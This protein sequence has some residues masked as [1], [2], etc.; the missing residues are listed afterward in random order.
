[1]WAGTT[2]LMIER[3]K[4]AVMIMKKVALIIAAAMVASLLA[5]CG[6]GSGVSGGSN[7]LALLLEATEA[8][9]GTGGYRMR[10]DIEIGMGAGSAP[11]AMEIRADVQNATDGMRQH[12]FVTMGGFEAEAYIVGDTYYQ[13]TPGEGW[14]KMSLGLYKAQ[15]M[16]MGLAD[17]DQVELMAK[18]AA[19]SR[20][21][22][23]KDGRVGIAFHL[24][25]EYFDASMQAYRKY[26][27]EG[28]Q[29][30]SPEWLDMIEGSVKDFGADIRMWIGTTSGLIER[31]E[32]EYSMSGVPQVGEIT[33]ST[34]LDLYDHDQALEI[35]L[36]PE[37]ARAEEIELSP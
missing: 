17:V 31:M 4:E 13:N 29:E 32:I 11:I 5:G 22:E 24:G 36:P 7:A 34:R 37:A 26:L 28:G 16:N 15:N 18:M 19:D 9:K 20:I 1:L 21:L 23:E 6:G 2:G 10:G 8:M 14:R 33:S 25:K 3:R 30:V 35:E 12:M 27:E